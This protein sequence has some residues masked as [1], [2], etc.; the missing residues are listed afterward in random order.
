MGP[1]GNPWD[2]QGPHG[3]Y[4][5]HGTHKTP[6]DTMGTHGDSI[7][8]HGHPWGPMGTHGIARSRMPTWGP[9]V[10]AQH[11]LPYDH[12]STQ[13]SKHTRDSSLIGQRITSFG[14]ARTSRSSACI[15][16]CLL[17]GQDINND[18]VAL[19]LGKQIH[20]F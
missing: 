14:I 9:S 15:N 20:L 17:S 10:R 18:L 5:T 8:H 2:P 19:W 7:G 12:A 1:P 4:G 6:W 11:S 3:I 13:H 16:A